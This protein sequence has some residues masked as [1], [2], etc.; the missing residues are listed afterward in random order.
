MW[1]CVQEFDVLLKA[2]FVTSKEVVA[3]GA[4]MGDLLH[5]IHTAWDAGTGP[6]PD[7]AE[8]SPHYPGHHTGLRLGLGGNVG[9][10]A[11]AVHGDWAVAEGGS[12]HILDLGDYLD[13]LGLWRSRGR[14]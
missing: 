12:V 10:A 1:W 3:A 5:A 2:A 4:G 13:T 8:Q 14:V 6:E 11:G 9:L 7:E